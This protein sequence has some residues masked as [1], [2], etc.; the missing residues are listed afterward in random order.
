M[1]RLLSH[2]TPFQIQLW[3]F[4]IAL[5]G[6]IGLCLGL[7]FAWWFALSYGWC[8]LILVLAGVMGATP[9]AKLVYDVHVGFVEQIL[10]G[11]T[12]ASHT[13]PPKS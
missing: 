5:G 12:T 8:V 2:C 3:F 10:R 6:T 4:S 7:A 1:V 13:T 9:C 11:S